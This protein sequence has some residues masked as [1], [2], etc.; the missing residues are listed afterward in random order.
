[1]FYGS[2]DFCFDQMSNTEKAIV[3]H[4]TRFRRDLI[5]FIRISPTQKMGLSHVYIFLQL[6]LYVIQSL[7]NAGTGQSRY[8][9]SSVYNS[10]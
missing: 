9:Y 10:S 8:P 1:M 3:T 7:F 6:F 5:Y 2:E 4:F